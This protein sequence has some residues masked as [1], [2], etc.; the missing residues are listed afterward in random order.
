MRLEE[1]HVLGKINSDLTVPACVNCHDRQ[2]Q[3]QNK[4]SPR[5]RS[6]NAMPQER[7]AYGM[8]TV[9]EHLITLGEETKRLALKQL[10]DYNGHSMDTNTPKETTGT[11]EQSIQQKPG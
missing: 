8:L 2:T 11:S 7:F 9:S 1:H 5:Q 3:S 6:A 10:E 4:L